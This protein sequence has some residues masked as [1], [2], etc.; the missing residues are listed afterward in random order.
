MAVCILARPEA[1][2]GGADS[3][4]YGAERPGGC[5]LRPPEDEADIG[6]SNQTTRSIQDKSEAGFA[7]LDRRYHIPNQLEID[8]GDNDADRR[9]IANN[10]NRH[11]WFGAS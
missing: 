9:S 11:V 10:R 5:F 6:V 4:A 3:V 7:Y 2:S 8:F 1:R